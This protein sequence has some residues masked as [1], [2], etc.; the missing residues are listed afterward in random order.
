VAAGAD[1]MGGSA[2]G[3]L[4]ST[5]VPRRKRRLGATGGTQTHTL[6]NAETPVTGF[7]TITS[8]AIGASVGGLGGI[9]L[10]Y[11]VGSAGGGQAHL[12]VQPTLVLNYI[13]YT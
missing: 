7:N 1:N 5:D 8:T 9:G 4:T 10:V 13:I 3:R 11:D 6:T 2:A 12:N